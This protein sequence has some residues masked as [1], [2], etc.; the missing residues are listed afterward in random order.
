MFFFLFKSCSYINISDCVYHSQLWFTGCSNGNFRGGG[1]GLLVVIVVT[2][3][4][5]DC[6][7]PLVAVITYANVGGLLVVQVVAYEVIVDVAYLF[8]VVVCLVCCGSTVVI[9][10]GAY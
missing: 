8:S 5:G 10:V 7:T 1:C 9:L 3:M 4:V 2:S 6:G